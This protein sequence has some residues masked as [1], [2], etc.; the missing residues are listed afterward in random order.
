MNKSISRF[1]KKLSALLMVILSLAAIAG[2]SS[3]QELFTYSLMESLQRDPSSLPPEQQI[4]YAESALASG[5]TA[6][7]ADIYDE[8]VALAASDP[9][10][11]LLAADLAMGASGITDVLGDALA[12]PGS[13]D[14]TTGLASIDLGML[15]NVADNVI[16]AETAGLAS[17]VTDEQY[18]AAAGAEVLQF[19]EGGG[20]LSTI[21]WTDSTS[22][23]LSGTEIENAYN[24]LISAGQDPATFDDIFGG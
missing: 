8:I 15:A 20:D 22:A 4:S 1:R 11:Y 5:D 2:I 9:E 10:L 6:A 3:C 7:M 24:F 14:Y 17:I 12:D 19:L 13:F 18:V 23:A 21:D 16:A